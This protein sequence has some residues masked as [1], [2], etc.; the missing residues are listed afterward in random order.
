LGPQKS[1]ALGAPH[2][3]KINK[4]MN[5]NQNKK[6]KREKMFFFASSASIVLVF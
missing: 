5:K 2:V 3:K 4:K 6:I 1:A